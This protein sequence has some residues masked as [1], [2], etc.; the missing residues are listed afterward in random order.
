MDNRQLFKVC[1]SGAAGRI[2]YSLYSAIG[3]GDLFGSETSID[4]RLLDLATKKKELEV[5]VMELEDCSFPLIEKVSIHHS[6]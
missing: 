3:T 6:A 2:A 4:L 1:V 5:I